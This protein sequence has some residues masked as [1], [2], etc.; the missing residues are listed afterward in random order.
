[1]APTSPC[2]GLRGDEPKFPV[3]GVATPSGVAEALVTQ[4]PRVYGYQLWDYRVNDYRLRPHHNQALKDLVAKIASD[5]RSGRFRDVNWQ[6]TV[7]GFASR[8]GSYDHN[9]S[10]SYW[11]MTTVARCLE[12]LISQAGLPAGRVVLGNTASHGYEGAVP[13]VEDPRRR[14]VQ[15]AIHPPNLQPPPVKPPS[16]RF[17]L[18][19]TSLEAT[20]DLTVPYTFGILGIGRTKC[21]FRIE[22]LKTGESQNYRYEGMGVALQVPL[23]KIIKKVIPGV[24]KALVNIVGKLLSQITPGGAPPGT[25]PCTNFDVHVFPTPDPRRFPPP[26]ITVRSFGGEMKMGVPAPGLGAV[27]MSFNNSLFRFHAKAL[28][29]PDPIEVNVARSLSPRTLV[30]TQGQAT[31]VAVPVRE[32]LVAPGRSSAMAGAEFVYSY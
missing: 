13:N 25:G 10:L 21:T 20:S 8:T 24:P 5:V 3:G 11:R 4:E 9:L 14:L 6:I 27:M 19:V 28:V 15:V 26:T 22:D 30:A 7:D 29:K 1:M 32:A 17:R 18:C 23:G 12:C 31:R 16:D 2:G